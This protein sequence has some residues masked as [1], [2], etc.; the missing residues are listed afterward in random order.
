[1]LPNFII[2]GG[3]ATGTSFLSAALAHHP[4]IYL[5]RV[6]RPEPNFFHYSW[7]Y[8]QGI[9]WYQRTWFHEVD[10]QPAVGERSSLLLNSEVAPARIKQ[11][12]PE[13]KLIFCLRNPVERAWGNYRFSVLEGLESLPFDEALEREEERVKRAEGHWTEVQPN[14]YSRRSRY[15][16]SLKEYFSLFGE[17]R[18]LLL[19]SESLGQNPE[20]GIARVCRFLGVDPTVALPL[21]PNYSS[22]SVLNPPLQADLRAYFGPRFAEIVEGIRKGDDLST[23]A[24]S[25]EDI[26]NIQRLCLNLGSGKE[27]LP[28]KSR[29]MLQEILADEVRELRK[30]VD[31][32]IDDWI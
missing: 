26:K 25:A 21:P 22:P 24:D 32:P 4:E 9:D 5:P 23:F 3:V 11:H 29:R 17:G 14:A 15:S 27:P 19:K 31:F 1:M 16:A 13:V 10:R 20:E 18:I 2:A 30:L 7:K 12:L 28:E 8:A 6:Q